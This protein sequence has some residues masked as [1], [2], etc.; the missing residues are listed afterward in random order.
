[1][2]SLG[3]TEPLRPWGGRFRLEGPQ[4]WKNEAAA[5]PGFL[6]EAHC[7]L[8]RG[9]GSGLGEGE[10]NGVHGVGGGGRLPD[11]AG[12]EAQELEQQGLRC[13]GWEDF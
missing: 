7:S 13:L 2:R 3:G 12:R 6:E 11:L 1:M 9:E 10:G 5:I 8:C 4:R